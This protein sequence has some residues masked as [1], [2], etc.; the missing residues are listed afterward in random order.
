MKYMAQSKGNF[1]ESSKYYALLFSPS[2]A[3]VDHLFYSWNKT[4]N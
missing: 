3:A 2:K 1:K 4:Y